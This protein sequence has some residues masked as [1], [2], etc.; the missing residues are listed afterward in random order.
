MSVKSATVGHRF[1]ILCHILPGRKS[2][3]FFCSTIGSKKRNLL[4]CRVKKE[5]CKNWKLLWISELVLQ[6]K[7]MQ[8]GQHIEPKKK[9]LFNEL[10]P[11]SIVVWYFFFC[12]ILPMHFADFPLRLMENKSKDSI[13]KEDLMA[14]YFGGIGNKT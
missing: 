7:W 11:D 3:H 4:M 10:L 6:F 12:C 14:F 13:F 1:F 2:W 8:G 5:M 9:I